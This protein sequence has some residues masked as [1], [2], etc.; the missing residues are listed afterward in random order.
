MQNHV[1]SIREFT[2]M[3][4]ITLIDFDLN[5]CDYMRTTKKNFFSVLKFQRD[6]ASSINVWK[7]SDATFLFDP[8]NVF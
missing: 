3:K 8:G 5:G 4:I 7:E 1:H 6:R 2:D